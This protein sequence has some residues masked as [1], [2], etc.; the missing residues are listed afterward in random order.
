MAAHRKYRC[1]PQTCVDGSATAVQ[2]DAR[3]VRRRDPTLPL[4]PGLNTQPDF[5]GRFARRSVRLD[6]E[7]LETL[8]IHFG[9][10]AAAT[11]DSD[12]TRVATSR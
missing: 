6:I 8:C 7:H 11:S 10:A 9:A 1:V 12:A 3:A 2:E 5:D 4:S